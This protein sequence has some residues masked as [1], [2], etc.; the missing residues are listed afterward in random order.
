MGSSIN[1]NTN[2]L[3]HHMLFANPML[4]RIFEEL[5]G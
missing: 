5:N 2:D 3:M 4:S 1:K